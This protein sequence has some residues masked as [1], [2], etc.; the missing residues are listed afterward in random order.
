MILDILRILS[1]KG[2]EYINKKV[3]DS[4]LEETSSTLDKIRHQK[5]R[6]DTMIPIIYGEVMLAGNIIWI[7][8][9]KE[10]DL[11]TNT[12]ISSNGLF[13]V[14]FNIFDFFGKNPIKE[15]DNNKKAYFVD[16]AVGICEGIVDD[17]VAIYINGIAHDVSSLDIKFYF[18][19]QNQLPNETIL[20]REGYE[21]TPA[22]RGLCYA[23]FK[24]FCV[25]DYGG[26]IPKIEFLLKRHSFE[27]TE[28]LTFKLKNSITAINLIPGSG[29]FVYE[30]IPTCT[31]SGFFYN[32]KDV[33]D[34]K[35]K[36][37]NTNTF[38]KTKADVLVALDQLKKDLPRLELVSVVVCW[39]SDS[40]DIKNA[41]IFPA[42]EFNDKKSASKPVWWFCAG[43][44]R[45]QT[46]EISRRKD[47]SL[48]YGGTVCD[49]SLINLLKELKLMGYKIALYPM[50]FVDLEEKPWRGR[51]TGAAEDVVNFFNKTDGYN[52]FILHYAKLARDFIDVFIIGSEMVGLTGLRDDLGC[53]PAVK[54]FVKLAQ[55]VRQIVSINTK[56]TYAADWSE[57]HSSNG[58][59]NMDE[60]WASSFIDFIGIDAYF[61]L[62]EG[63]GRKSIE[64]IKQGWSSGEGYDFFYKD[65]E[66]VC[67]NSSAFAWK[68]F[69]WF[70]ENEHINIDGTKTH[71]KP[72]VKK[73]WFT[74][75]GFPSVDLCTN[76]P[77]VFY[78]PTS[79]ESFF[80]KHSSG[81]P[82]F[83]AQKEALFAS[84]EFIKENSDII[85]NASVWCY[86]LRPYPFF[87]KN[88]DVWADG[89]LWQTGH[90]LN[91]KLG[92]NTFDEVVLDLSLRVGILQNEME[93]F[94]SHDLIE[95]F[96]INQDFS[97]K[98]YISMLCDLFSVISSTSKNGISFKSLQCL[99]NN[100]GVVRINNIP[101]IKKN[102]VSTSILESSIIE[103][104][105]INEVVIFFLDK[106]CKREV[107]TYCLSLN[108]SPLI[109]KN[110]VNFYIPLLLSKERVA[111]IAAQ[112]LRRYYDERQE[113][114]F[115][116]P[117]NYLTV[118]PLDVL[119]LDDETKMYVSEIFFT[120]SFNIEVKCKLLTKQILPER[121]DVVIDHLSNLPMQIEKNEVKV[122]I[123]PNFFKLNLSSPNQIVCV[124]CTIT[125]AKLFYYV[126]GFDQ[127]NFLC[128]L[129]AK[130]VKGKIIFGRFE[131]NIDDLFID[132]AS[133]VEVFVECAGVINPKVLNYGIFGGRVCFFYGIE[134]KGE[135]HYALTS[136]V[137]K[138][139]FIDG[140]GE[141]DFVLL[142]ES[143]KLD[144]N[145]IQEDVDF[146]L[147]KKNKIL[148]VKVDLVRDF[149][150]NDLFVGN[151]FLYYLLDG[152]LIWWQIYSQA[153]CV[154]FLDVTA[155]EVEILFVK[156]N[157]KLICKGQSIFISNQ[158]QLELFGS[159]QYK[160]DMMVSL[161]L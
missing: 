143:Y 124:F 157:K 57:Y 161:L 50:I 71:F 3:E 119:I 2:F 127:V 97:A 34:G 84:L 69:R 10:T 26:V 106:S 81:I 18:G 28:S 63:V 47:G 133:Y 132:N 17:L 59:Y 6:Y 113:R 38:D 14:V 116:L 99:N 64:K 43:K 56:I 33:V 32:E 146:V 55:K 74:E 77:N 75:F 67:Y 141:D 30:T 79:K 144:I 125:Q 73:I 92:A 140:F 78:D 54:E 111:N 5:R 154:E 108:D 60:L 21:R 130:M 100:A 31:Y 104:F 8:D 48:N 11:E 12:F 24:D 94:E 25:S 118:S 85:E 122:F 52:N 62:T 88:L 150:Q 66:K 139:V 19:T 90:F 105:F 1:K 102:K 16:F 123:L 61:P 87:P 115:V 134:K 37:S 151:T 153:D 83:V 20:L 76:Q 137:Y 149:A 147:Y 160:P 107:S 51:I 22:F 40:I 131:T 159:L 95:G 114:T 145:F 7:G 15:N 4:L 72:N 103:N 35:I 49:T 110:R 58:F 135:S 93:F 68:N 152:I 91:G 45:W 86:D 138:N 117:L 23:V 29:E 128:N 82:D 27:K 13:N 148:D 41:S 156:F 158:E 65:G 80:P 9:L 96:C 120:E 44:N 36:Y 53:F 89:V 46:R 136:F 109:K 155:I 129:N 70:L 142:T 101:L 39:F 98:Y 42:V 126:K 112:I 121:Q